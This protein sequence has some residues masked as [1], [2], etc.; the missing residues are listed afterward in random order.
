[1]NVS[2]D[3]VDIE[4]AR[5]ELV[6]ACRDFFASRGYCE[7]FT[8]VM[9]AAP[10]ME[11]NIDAVPC[12][13]GYLRTSPELQMKILIARGHSRI[14]QIGPCFRLGELGPLHRPEF[15]MLEWYRTRCTHLDILLETRCLLQGILRRF[16]EAGRPPAGA[17]RL[18]LKGPWETITVREAFLRSAGW[19]PIAE[20]DEDRFWSDLVLKVEP[21]LPSEVPVV[22]TEYPAAAGGFARRKEQDPRIAERW[23]LYVGG[24]EI[25]NGCAEIISRQEHLE[26]LQQAA[27]YRRRHGKPLYPIDEGFLAALDHMP[28][29]AGVAVGLDRL[30][31]VLLGYESLDE[32]TPPAL[33]SG[34]DGPDG[35]QPQRS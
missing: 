27:D 5:A 22:L 4:R 8:P 13:D 16:E 33:S 15:L 11:E 1:M 6:G 7:V 17:N 29:C 24:V 12:R 28:S 19:D 14:F 25:A 18:G 31:M 30:L 34:A 10:A 35:H 20:F 9:I 21:D 26:R 32:V 23:E 2:S 3:G